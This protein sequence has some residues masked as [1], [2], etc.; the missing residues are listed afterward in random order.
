M[1][2]YGNVG[3]W[4]KTMKTHRLSYF[5]VYGDIPDGMWVLHHCDNPRCVRPSHLFLGDNSANIAD[6]VAKRRQSYGSQRPEA[7]LNDRKV[8]IIRSLYENGQTQD[9][10]AKRFGVA[11]ATI[12]T[13]VRREAWKHV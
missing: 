12:G 8:G 5:L 10:I 9:Q 13:I 2:G 1:A 7:K 6:M 11:S 3:V 4:G